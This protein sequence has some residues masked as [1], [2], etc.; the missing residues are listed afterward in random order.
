M[1][2][3][4]RQRT[5]KSQLG[6][7]PRQNQ[8]AERV[9]DEALREREVQLLFAGEQ[10]RR[11]IGSYYEASPGSV[12][13]YPRRLEDLLDDSRFVGRR[14]HLRKIYRD[15]MSGRAEWGIVRAPDGGLAGVYSRSEAKPLKTA[16]FA[17]GQDAFNGAERYSAWE[18]IYRPVAR[19]FK[20]ATNSSALGT[21]PAR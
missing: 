20:P 16:G 14:R 1:P 8:S 12:K 5:K 19:E 15:P 2:A 6:L 11:A 7:I 4:I 13:Q 17:T 10:F 3:F 18:F 21:M 9:G